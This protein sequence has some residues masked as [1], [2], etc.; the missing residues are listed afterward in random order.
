M[1][2]GPEL[3]PH[4]YGQLPLEAAVPAGPAL[5]G[6]MSTTGGSPHTPLLAPATI[7][8]A[9]AIACSNAP[10]LADLCPARH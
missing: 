4:L 7:K 1:D 9:S 8:Q 6:H 3:Y 5:P 10:D 2:G